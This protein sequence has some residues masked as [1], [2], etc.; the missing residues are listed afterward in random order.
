MCLVDTCPGAKGGYT[1]HAIY[2]LFLTLQLVSTVSTLTYR[3]LGSRQSHAFGVCGQRVLPHSERVSCA[4]FMETNKE[5]GA[6]LGKEKSE[7]DGRMP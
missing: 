6:R 3:E 2:F 4:L 5:E 1:A 7:N